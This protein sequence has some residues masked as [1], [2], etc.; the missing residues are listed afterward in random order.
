MISSLK[1]KKFSLSFH[2][3]QRKVLKALNSPEIKVAANFNHA[4]FFFFIQNQS[5]AL[6]KNIA[7]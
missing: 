4:W 2:L 3:G 7:V 5:T 6:G 1:K